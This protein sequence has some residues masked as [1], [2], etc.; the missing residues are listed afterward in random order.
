MINYKPLIVVVFS[1]SILCA[2]TSGTKAPLKAGGPPVSPALYDTI[3]R[4]DSVLFN[5]FNTHNLSV[6]KNFFSDNL[7]FYH[8][9][10]GVSNYDQN[11]AAFEKTF[12]AERKL[13]RQLV[14]NSLEVYPIKDFGAVEIGVHQFY[15]T[16]KGQEEHLGSEAK[17]IHLWQKINGTWKITRVI[18]YAHLEVE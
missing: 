2:F 16:E 11:I 12:A 6:L 4:L 8:D 18:S 13:R 14:P 15:V 5:A 3:A 7:E 17:F 10:G 1:I 9:L